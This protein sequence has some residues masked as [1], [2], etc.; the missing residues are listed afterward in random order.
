[1]TT[2]SAPSSAHASAQPQWHLVDWDSQTPTRGEQQQVY[3]GV[4]AGHGPLS[5]AFFPL[6]AGRVVLP[7]THTRSWAYVSVLAGDA[8]TVVGE[9]LVVVRHRVG[10]T[11]VIPP[12]ELHA[13]VS[14]SSYRP[15]VVVEV[16]SEQRWNDELQL[17]PELDD[18][19]ASL[20]AT[21]Q[22]DFVEPGDPVTALDIL[23]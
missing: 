16:R 2:Y 13:A 3:T 9:D 17:R 21:L 15:T 20:A 19:V 12:G 23:R 10:Q 8:A 5:I 11:L 18:L 14:L 1:M 4:V 7:H 6:P 22:R